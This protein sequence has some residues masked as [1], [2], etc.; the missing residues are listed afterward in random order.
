MRIWSPNPIQ[1]KCPESSIRSEDGAGAIA[2]MRVA[3]SWR[4]TRAMAWMSCHGVRSLC[5]PLPPAPRSAE[6]PPRRRL[7]SLHRL[8]RPCS[9][10]LCTPR[11]A[12]SSA[13]ASARMNRDAQLMNRGF[14]VRARLMP[15]CGA[16]SRVEQCHVPACTF[17]PSSRDPSTG[18]RCHSTGAAVPANTRI[19]ARLNCVQEHLAVHA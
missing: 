2:R 9:A 5:G 14:R 18:W 11:L 3:S 6:E 13:P 4:A 17:Q 1:K 7:H 16:C 10:L 19:P 15:V 12:R 8:R